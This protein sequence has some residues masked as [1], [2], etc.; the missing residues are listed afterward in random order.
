M[1]SSSLNTALAWDIV[2]LQQEK[3]FLK[4]LEAHYYLI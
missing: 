4:L 2:M 3:S 1:V